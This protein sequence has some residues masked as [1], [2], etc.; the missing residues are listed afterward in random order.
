MRKRRRLASWCVGSASFDSSRLPWTTCRGEKGVG[1]RFSEFEN[2]ETRGF[3][4]VID[5][6]S[7]KIVGEKRNE[8]CESEV[9]RFGYQD[10]WSR[11]KMPSTIR[12]ELRK[13]QF[14]FSNQFSI[15]T[16]LHLSENFIRPVRWIFEIRRSSWSKK[17]Y[18]EKWIV[19]SLL[20][21]NCS[22]K[23][24]FVASCYFFSSISY[25][26]GMRYIATRWTEFWSFEFGEW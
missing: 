22:D 24:S 16:K 4:I 21:M 19:E 5:R 1:V 23:W 3:E 20:Y 18:L 11:T 25:R 9:Y 10:M 7:A 14:Y 12:G 26:N 13:C 2:R 6:I 15:S 17:L 8:T